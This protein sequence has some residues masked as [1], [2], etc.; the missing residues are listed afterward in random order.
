M[1]SV[2]RNKQTL[3]IS[4]YRK[5]RAMVA[6]QYHFVLWH[7]G[8]VSVINKVSKKEAFKYDNRH[9]GGTVVRLLQHPGIDIILVCTAERIFRV[10]KAPDE[11]RDM[12][13]LYVSL[14]LN[15]PIAEAGELF[16]K[17]RKHCSNPEQAN[18]V[19]LTEAEFYFDQQDYEKAA[20]KYVHSTQ[21][22]EVA[23]PVPVG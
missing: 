22:S 20:K 19:D 10:V 16:A 3:D 2:L 6:T 12:W 1:Q 14:A 8:G 5:P 15:A 17:A 18:K 23:I 13:S 9:F 11:G 21:Q 7:E 4:Q